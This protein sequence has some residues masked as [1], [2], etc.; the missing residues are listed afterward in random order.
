[1]SILGLVDRDLKNFYWKNADN[2]FRVKCI[3]KQN[4]RIIR[5]EINLLDKDLLGKGIT[6][7]IQ[8]ERENLQDYLLNFGFDELFSNNISIYIKFFK[9][10]SY[11]L[12]Q[13]IKDFEFYNLERIAFNRIMFLK[14][15]ILHEINSYLSQFDDNVKITTNST[16]RILKIENSHCEETQLK[17]IITIMDL[18]EDTISA[19]KMED[20]ICLQESILNFNLNTME[21]KV[22]VSIS[23]KSNPFPDF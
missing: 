22:G 8:I 6:K 14:N 11:Y 13:K 17:A 15:C 20:E 7:I 2:Y 5:K 3:I 4:M 19:L 9:S 1:M 23:D 18:I 16:E 12:L 21:R 10:Y